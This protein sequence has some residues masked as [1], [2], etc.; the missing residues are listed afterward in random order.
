MMPSGSAMVVEKALMEGKCEVLRESFGEGGE[1]RS[2]R[3]GIGEKRV[4]AFDANDD[5]DDD[6]DLGLEA[7]VE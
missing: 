7:V 6:D 3:D 1:E 4:I 5:D 2:E